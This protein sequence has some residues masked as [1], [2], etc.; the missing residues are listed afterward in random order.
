MYYNTIGLMSGTSLDG[1]DIVHVSFKREKQW[2]FEIINGN[3]FKYS[4]K[5]EDQLK[6]AHILQSE[7]L[8]IKHNEYG[9]YLGQLINR[10]I[11]EN[12]IDKNSIHFISSHGHTIFHQPKNQFT[13]QLGSGATI[14]AKTG[15]KTISDFRSLDLAFGGQGAP[16]VPIGDHLLFN[17]FDLC[18]NIGGI[19]NISFMDNKERIAGDL[20]FANM[21][22]NKLCNTINLKYDHNGDLAKKGNLNLELLKSLKKLSYF[23]K[24]FPKSLALEDFEKWYYPIIE[25]SSIKI[26]DKLHTTGFHL[27]ETIAS[28]IKTKN[29]RL[30]ITGGGAFNKF[31]MQLLKDHHKLNLT[32]PKDNI[33]N[34]KEAIIFA[35]LGVLNQSDQNNTL[36]SVTGAIKNLKTGVIHIP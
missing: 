36:S 33:I 15:I 21:T 12:K 28:I 16:L 2:S 30:L 24:G 29:H 19:A 11:K 1:V 14:A 3:T 10:F 9:S 23:N 27:C 25:N 5:W 4:T 32:K 35:F 18:L 22:S 8:L 6:T 13:F 7:K 31:W 20:N 26:E 34:F 17:E